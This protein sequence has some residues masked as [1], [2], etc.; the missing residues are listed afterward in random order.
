MTLL[1]LFECGPIA[2]HDD[3]YQTGI[4][5]RRWALVVNHA[6]VGF[7]HQCLYDDGWSWGAGYYLLGVRREWRLGYYNAY[8]DGDHHVVSLGPFYF[9]WSS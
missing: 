5:G 2:G 4:K 8:Y 3:R 6:G 1:S 9:T 7:E